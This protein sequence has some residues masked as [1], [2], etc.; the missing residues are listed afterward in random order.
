MIK[1]KN[2]I[3]A[4]GVIF[5]ERTKAV[6]IFNIIEDLIVGGF[7]TFIQQLS[8]FSYFTR[9]AGDQSKILLKLVIKNNEKEIANENIDV[10]FQDKL[11]NRT[12]IEFSAMPIFEEGKVVFSI[13][14]QTETLSEYEIS[15]KKLG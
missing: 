3:V 9:E 14:N 4:T 12:R 5:D 1:A 11:K 10:N 13:M 15:V 2:T 6:S 8:L 7:P